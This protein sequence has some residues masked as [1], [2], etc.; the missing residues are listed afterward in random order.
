VWEETRA[1]AEDAI[2]FA[3][4]SPE[5]DPATLTRNVYTD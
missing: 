5:P 4:S 1:D 2:A 3:Q